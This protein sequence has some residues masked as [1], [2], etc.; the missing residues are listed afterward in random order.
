MFDEF[1]EKRNYIFNYKKFYFKVERLELLSEEVNL[2]VGV[3]KYKI[4]YISKKTNKIKK[5]VFMV[6]K[7]VKTKDKYI[8]N[9]IQKN[10]HNRIN[11]YFETMKI[12]K[13]NKII[14]Y[15]VRRFKELENVEC[16]NFD[17]AELDNIFFMKDLSLEGEVFPI[18]KQDKF[19]SEIIEKYGEAVWM[20][21]FER[22]IS[23]I[24]YLI[25]KHVYISSIDVWLAVFNGNS[26]ELEIIDLDH[27]HFVNF[28]E[29]IALSEL[30]VNIS[31]HL[32]EIIDKD[33]FEKY[34][35]IIKKH[36]NPYLENIEREIESDIYG[37]CFDIVDLK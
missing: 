24:I 11:K 37:L 7:T 4:S 27:F 31:E 25:K 18:N 12:L 36:F 2:N 5:N 13:N 14:S 29:S 33:N 6:G 32:T 3:Y 34:D 1:F 10:N 23:E 17:K 28:I 26:F 15:S 16:L 21:V 22:I 8:F 9:P 30:L 35:K 20:V 19:N